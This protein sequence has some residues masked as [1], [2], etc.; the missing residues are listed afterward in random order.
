M[1]NGHALSPPLSFM[2]AVPVG[3]Q[4]R[5][6]A[7]GRPE[8]LKT[9]TMVTEC[10]WMRSYGSGWSAALRASLRPSENRQSHAERC[11]LCAVILSPLGFG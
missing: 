1:I 6:I 9:A 11:H 4:P 10:D 3:P 2:D 8:L 7:S 5:S